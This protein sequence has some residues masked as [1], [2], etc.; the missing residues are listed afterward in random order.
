MKF[1][2]KLLLRRFAHF[3]T[4]RSHYVVCNALTEVIVT[5]VW[6]VVLYS[7]CTHDETDHQRK[8]VTAFKPDGVTKSDEIHFNILYNCSIEMF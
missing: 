7:T 1:L 4:F 5:L 2:A 8:N 6:L 3:C